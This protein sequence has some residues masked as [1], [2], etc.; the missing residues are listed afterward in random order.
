MEHILDVAG[1]ILK[2]YHEVTKESLD[3]MKLHK[4]LYFTQRETFTILGKAAF[5]E[6]LEG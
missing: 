5:A 1:Y 3:E 4:L 6:D 2:R